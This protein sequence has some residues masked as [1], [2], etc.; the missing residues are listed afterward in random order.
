MADMYGAV[1]SNHIKC[2][3]KASALALQKLVTETYRFGFE[4]EVWV[5]GN[6]VAFGGH[7]QYPSAWPKEPGSEEDQFEEADLGAF[8]AAVRPLM[9]KG[10]VLCVVAAGHEKLRYVSASQLIVTQDPAIEPV[11]L[12]MGSDTDNTTL[13]TLALD[14]GE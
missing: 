7:E 8:A 5:D 14:A 12:Y 10:A 4:T 11:F 6:V 3:D 2:K 13:L 1:R 9:A